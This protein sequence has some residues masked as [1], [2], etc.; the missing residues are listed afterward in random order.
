M[1]SKIYVRMTI[2]YMRI[3]CTP[4]LASSAS[5]LQLLNSLYRSIN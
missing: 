4:G 5:G 3:S 2:T 1:F